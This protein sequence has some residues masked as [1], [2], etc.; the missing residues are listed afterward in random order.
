[1]RPFFT[2]MAGLLLSWPA[3][4]FAQDGDFTFGDIQPSEWGMRQYP[5][6]SS[7]HAVVLNEFG[8]TLIDNHQ[9]NVLVHRY[10]VRIKVLDAQ[11]VHK[12]DF[13]IP[14]HRDEKG[15]AREDVRDVKAITYNREGAETT[16]SRLRLKNVFTE[17]R[18]RYTDLVKF[19]LPNV[20]AGSILEVSY[21]FSSP[22]IYNFRTWNFQDDI[23]KVR[24]EYWAR[25]P[26]NL[27]YNISLTGYLHLD[28]NEKSL[29]HDCLIEFNGGKAD[30]VLMKLGM[31]KVPAFHDE[32]YMT[33]RT[34][35][36]SSVQFELAEIKRFNGSVDKVAITWKD[37]D[38][39][40]ATRKDFGVELKKGESFFRDH[41]DTLLHAGDGPAARARRIYRFFQGWY[42]WNGYTGMSCESGIREAF[43]HRSGNIGDINLG[44]VAALRAAGLKADPLLLSTRDNGL[45]HD[46]YPVISDFNYVLARLSLPEGDVLL[47]ASSPDL[48]F[49]MFPMECINGRGRL[50]PRG[51]SSSW[52]PLSAPA[53][54][55]AVHIA[56]LSLGTDGVIRGSLTNTYS[57]Y[58]ALMHR[59]DIKKHN[60]LAAYKE[61]VAGRWVGIQV[62][63][64]TILHLNEPERPLEEKIDI[65]MAIGDGTSRRLVFN[66][67][68][69]REIRAN[70]FKLPERLF[71][72]DFGAPEELYNIVTLE[73]PEGYTVTA[74]PGKTLLSLQGNGGSYGLDVEQMGHTIIVK[75]ILRQKK[76]IYSADE[77]TALKELYNRIIQSQRADVV[78]AKP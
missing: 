75:T 59:H 40:L 22:F 61:A 39:E 67:F 76:A 4:L 36:L 55:K 69:Q 43:S 7:A 21:T 30:C 64:D 63:A 66:P 57:G 11:G 2:L 62:T 5:G 46:L 77:Y 58:M 53:P 34:N 41:L 23:P 71:P 33:A 49:G 56:H 50:V 31:H 9:E 19:S 73:Y 13:V 27:V 70:P 37:A 1:M 6:D 16:E 35:F 38:D 51:D 54:L 29:V 18:S 24:S 60:S 12:A 3:T 47:D 14:V 15:K 20:R 78:L 74:A 48:P 52:L 25:I 8:E 28:K 65:S 45:P 26:A 32:E 17:N 10:H 72:V 44:L 42:R 68:L